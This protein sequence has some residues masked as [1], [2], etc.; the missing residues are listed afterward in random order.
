MTVHT[1]WYLILTLTIL[2]CS[3]VTSSCDS[4]T[5]QQVPEPAPAVFEQEIQN[6][7]FRDKVFPPKTQGILFVGSSSFWLWNAQVREDMSPLSIIPRG[8]GGSTMVDLLYYMDRIVLAYEPR[9]VVVYEGDNDIAHY[10]MSPGQVV[11]NF[12]SFVE[13]VH[14]RAPATRIYIVSIKPSFLRQQSWP[15]QLEA[16]RLLEELCATDDRLMY[17]DVATP[18]FDQSGDLREGLFIDDG[19]HMNA[20]GYEL[21]RSIIRPIL[22]RKEGAHEAAEG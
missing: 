11:D 3:S 5:V 12:A 8:F 14:E 2:V 17:I 13:A 20:R 19:L 9:A 15:I 4:S 18:M 22:M 7:E 10:D 16:N 21:W 1:S 6:F